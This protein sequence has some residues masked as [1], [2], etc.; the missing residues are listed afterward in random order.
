MLIGNWL[1]GTHPPCQLIRDRRDWN[2]LL[3]YTF[4]AG[5]GVKVAVTVRN[6]EVHSAS[7]LL[8]QRFSLKPC[9]H[10]CVPTTQPRPAVIS[11][12]WTWLHNQ[13]YTSYFVLTSSF[14]SCWFLSV[15]I[16]LCMSCWAGMSYLQF[17]PKRKFWEILKKNN[18]NNS[19][20]SR[21]GFVAANKWTVSLFQRRLWLSVMTGKAEA[22]P[23]QDSQSAMHLAFK[24]DQSR[25]QVWRKSCHK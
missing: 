23:V 21:F 2:K 10:C 5:R 24:R 15:P 6:L 7:S 18:N 22:A 12:G 25:W 19:L 11:E 20:S 16:Y 9:P 8:L 3:S 13:C 17:P 4:W 1:A 14:I